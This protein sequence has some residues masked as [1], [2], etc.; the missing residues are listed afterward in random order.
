MAERIVFEVDGKAYRVRVD[1]LKRSGVVTDGDNAGRL[2][3]SLE[4]VREI[5]GTFYNYTME[6]NTDELDFD[7]Y[8]D[9]FETLTDPDMDSHLVKLPYAQGYLTFQ[10]YVTQVDD[11]LKRMGEDFIWWGN[12]SFQ[13]I[14]MKPQRE[15]S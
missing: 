9:L 10:A 5:L 4:M 14:A 6:L 8:D 1:S 7:E 2:S 12:M 3:V 13:F 15:A 11:E